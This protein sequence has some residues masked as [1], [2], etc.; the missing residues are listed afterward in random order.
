MLGLLILGVALVFLATYL[1][2]GWE[3]LLG[4]A[5]RLLGLKPFE[6]KAAG[7]ADLLNWAAL[8]ADGVVQTKDG[9]LLA[10]FFY[11]G[12]D[13][14]ASTADERNYI[15]QRLNAALARLGNGWVSWHDAVRLP[16]PGYCDPKLSH[17]P[18]RVTAAIDEE[19]R[20]HFLSAGQLYESQY[21]L[22][23]MYTPPARRNTR[24]MDFIYDD[25]KHS[26]GQAS[27]VL[28][29]FQKTLD[30]LQD[31]I[32]DVL[33][34]R[35]MGRY[36]VAAPATDPFVRDELVNF[37]NF[38]LTGDVSPI[39]IPS[40]AM[41]LDCLLGMQDLWPGDMPRFGDQFVCSVSIAGFPGDSYPNMLA[42]LD[43]LP[44]AYRWS[45]RFIYLDQQN[46]LAALGA[47]RRK[48]R[49]KITGLA[50]QV[51]RTK[52]AQVN[53]DAL[54]M[55]QQVDTA[56]TDAHSALVTYGYYT[57]NVVLRDT[58]RQQLKE[59][60]RVVAREITR[61]GFTARIETV[62]AVEAWLGTLP[63][64]P[65]PNIRRPLIHTLNLADLLPLSSVWPGQA[66]NPCPLYPK[67]SPP[68]MYV[69]TTGWTPLRVN[70]HH[71][72]VGHTLLFGPT[73]AGK[74]VFLAFLAAQF[75]RYRH[76]TVTVFDKGRSMYGLTRAIF[77]ARHYDLAGEHG[78][79]GLCPLRYLDSEADT[80]W[81]EEWIATCFELIANRPTSPRQR[82]AIH[83][84]LRLLRSSQEGRSLTHFVAT[85]QDP[86]LREALTH[87]TI[88]GPLGRLLDDEQDSLN[89]SLFSVFEVEE[90]MG[91]GEKNLIPV[92]LYLF[93][94]FERSLKGQ[95][96]LLVLDEAWV[97]LG[98]P[99]FRGKI[100]EWL[101]V[102]RKAN[103]AVVLATQSLSDAA[104]SGILD[105]LMESCPTKILLPNEEA[106]KAG[107]STVLGPR[108]LYALFGL[109]EAE[110]DIIKNAQKKRQYYYISPLGR[111]LFELRL[112]PYALSFVA[113]SDKI[114]IARIRELADRYGPA[115]VDHWLEEKGIPHEKLSSSQ[116]A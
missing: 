77:A 116:A 104:S 74:S 60:A 69:A 10:G 14:A 93:R 33:P 80:A 65:R 113:A 15:T 88:D 26:N 114:S 85:V 11:Q 3:K 56:I 44:I 21:A 43:T 109:N 107:T 18:D 29:Q 52:N 90:L 30:D 67:S 38:T 62:N 86:E 106:D 79:P 25:D 2:G 81:A 13:L 84:A 99:V 100:R 115:W 51:F 28:E 12:K 78:S 36:E 94:R 22:T 63:G 17:F 66:V 98:H 57:A 112:G 53:E 32:G 55:S 48:W 35:R 40:C 41:Y 34:L 7:T 108:D 42:V 9:S 95:P 82:E 97:M 92:L 89:D 75:L 102:L 103:C 70:L 59:N 72:D 4:A 47:Y 73:G 45:T 54:A 87:Y 16:A 105:V 96:A 71:G 5:P 101:K 50:S 8:V 68:L 76:A 6:D 61:L 24:V 110:I 19:R 1:F 23:L 58:D 20:E 39:N 37:L 46:A 49:Q 91:M 83:K 111:R 31:A 64:H 27:R